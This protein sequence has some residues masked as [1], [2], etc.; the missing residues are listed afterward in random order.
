MK[1]MLMM[2]ATVGAIS[3]FAAADS[4]AAPAGP[5]SVAPGSNITLAAEGCGRGYHRIPNGR[6]VRNLGPGYPCWWVRG[7]YGAWRMVCR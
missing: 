5:M 3:A 6:C 1:K 2:L 7:P 4:K